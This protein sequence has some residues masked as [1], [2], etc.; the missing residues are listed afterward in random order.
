MLKHS[1]K[2]EDYNGDSVTEDFYF[3]LNKSELIEL[4]VEHKE[5]M[6][7]W[8]QSI[9]KADDRKTMLAEF[10]KIILLAY[11][12]KSPDG[13][14]FIKSDELREEFSQTAAYNALFMQ[15]ISDDGF[16]ANFIK[17]I[18]PKD[19]STEVDKAV[20]AEKVSPPIPTT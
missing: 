19:L 20:E 13:K 9:A 2:Y 18:L 11:G 6:Y 4:E 17:G 5:G 7:E 3:N 1:I 10:K 16:A 12:Q 14:R 15:L 8:I